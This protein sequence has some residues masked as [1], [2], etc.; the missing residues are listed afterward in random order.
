MFLGNFSRSIVLPASADSSHIEA[1]LK[2]SV[3][4]IILKRTEKENKSDKDQN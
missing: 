1:T 4:K 3:L 2:D